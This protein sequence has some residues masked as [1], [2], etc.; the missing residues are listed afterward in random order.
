MVIAAALAARCHALSAQITASSRHG[1]GK[2]AVRNS[3]MPAVNP[4]WTA[5][6][7]TQVCSRIF[8]VTGLSQP[9]IR[10]ARNQ[11]LN[12]DQHSRRLACGVVAALNAA[13]LG[14][15]PKSA[16]SLDGGSPRECTT[17]KVGSESDSGLSV[18]R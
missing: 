4:Y 16:R 2:R 7:N 10:L 13:R 5:N 8:I 12:N 18:R 6:M 15:N 9:S 3:D 1:E 14:S 17:S 11:R